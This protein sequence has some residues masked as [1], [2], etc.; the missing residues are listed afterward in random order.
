VCHPVI[1]KIFIPYSRRGDVYTG[2][3]LYVIASIAVAWAVRELMKRIPDT[4]LK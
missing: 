2:L 4:R 1:R 3:L